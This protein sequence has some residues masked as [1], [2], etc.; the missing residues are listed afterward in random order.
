VSTLLVSD[1][2]PPR[3]GG[4]GRWF[5][6][7][8]RRLPRADYCIA[9]GEAE[10]QQEFDR[11]HDLRLKRLPLTLHCWGLRGWRGY[12]RAVWR[13]RRLI[14]AE[15]VRVLHCGRALP[16]GLMALALK[17]CCRVSYLCYA[18]GEELNHAASSRELTWWV[19]RV[20]GSAARV[21]ANSRNTERLLREDW[22]LPAARVT[23]L[24]PGVDTRRFVPAE[25]DPQVRARL[26]WGDRPV[27]LTVGRLQ[28]RKGHDTTIQALS[29]IRRTV[30]N[31][32]YA[33]VGEGEER[34]PLQELAARLDLTGHVKFHGEPDDDDL[35][36]CYQQCDLF[37]L[38]NREVNGDIEGF[39]MVLLE[40]QACGRPVIAGAS[41]G[42]VETMRPGETG[43]VVPC[44]G[45]E[46][47][48]AL[49][50][51][52]LPDRER[53]TRMGEAGRRWVVEQFDWESLTRQ[54][55]RLFQGE[56]PRRKPDC[57]GK[58]VLS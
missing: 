18:H 21:I 34:Q 50:A 42:T 11:T 16:E 53:L 7:I 45:P 30:P 15:R 54:A 22:A 19:R 31:V 33:I 56:P 58:L 37:V 44:E 40:A 51:E 17:G 12:W 47:L 35:V 27:I 41:G 46:K 9:A 49:A 13:L 52:L 23:V 48:A 4:S 20:L 25:R 29:A 24:H 8:Y 57:K 1:L 10:R 43:Y 38:A 6:E 14:K 39:G 55:E 2:F 5:W 36:R 3:T 28:K 32:L 26:G